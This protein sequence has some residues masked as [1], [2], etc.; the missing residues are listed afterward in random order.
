MNHKR[1]KRIYKMQGYTLRQKRR[2][3]YKTEAH[4]FR[5]KI[6]SY[7][8]RNE[9][10]SMDFMSDQLWDGRRFRTFNIVDNITR[11]NVHIEVGFSLTSQRI[12]RVLDQLELSWGLPQL[13]FVDNGPEFRSKELDRWCS[14]RGIKLHFIDPGKPIQN[15]YIESFNGKFREECLNQNHFM[16]LLDA[17]QL[18][19]IWREEYN[20]VRPH[21]S[22]KGLTPYE[23]A[24][25]KGGIV[26]SA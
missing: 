14:T 17:E 18:I 11:E 25:K 4:H 26:V 13:I 20:H 15:A 10:W 3:R 22:L 23:F 19:H 5:L 9:V 24:K 2:R 16:S 21:S 7:T 6:P 12:C 8:G 1:I